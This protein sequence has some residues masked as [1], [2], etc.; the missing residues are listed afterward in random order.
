MRPKGWALACT[1]LVSV[2]CALGVSSAP[3]MAAP[4]TT[5]L[6][7]RTI[8]VGVPGTLVTDDDH[9]IAF[10]PEPGVI[11]TID[12]I[13]GARRDYDVRPT[14]GTADVALTGV[15]RGHAAFGCR[16]AGSGLR[17]SSFT[18]D[19]ASGE[20]QSI[21]AIDQ[22]EQDLGIPGPRGYVTVGAIGAYGVAA[23]EYVY[24]GGG[25]FVVNWRTGEQGPSLYGLDS[26][27]VLDL[28]SPTLTTKLCAPL[29]YDDT[30]PDNGGGDQLTYEYEPPFGLDRSYGYPLTLQRCGS[31]RKTVLV[32]GV[33]DA[34]PPALNS[35]LGG[36][37]VSWES[38]AVWPARP[39]RAD[40]NV[41]LP[42]CDAQMTWPIRPVEPSDAADPFD[43]PR[44]LRDGILVP[45]TVKDGVTEQYRQISLAGV[46]GRVAR[47]ARVAVTTRSM[48]TAASARAGEAVDSATGA[49]IPLTPFATT[50]R[51][52]LRATA[53]A[54]VVVKTGTSTRAVRWR[55]GGGRWHAARGH[56]VRWMLRLPRSRGTHV[57]RLRAAFS[58]GGN[59]TFEL[60]VPAIRR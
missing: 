60:R 33:A 54:A 7:G 52:T 44:H 47:A 43:P 42:A 41:Y 35:H 31:T 3:A 59:A 9:T 53:A 56:G 15:G 51:S 8:D 14:C 38:G 58:A 26:Q 22:I 18:L 5:K 45:T 48:R 49:T 12:A 40:P 57:L 19:L 4:P 16:V 10:M 29:S 28:D 2:A 30:Q 27:T 32:R 17:Y 24:H 13:T 36:G 55:L 37:F 23:T 6:P 1:S 25:E 20:V 21:T 39:M 34:Y 11:R 46:C 50:R